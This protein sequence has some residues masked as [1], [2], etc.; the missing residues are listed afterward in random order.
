MSL[1]ISS[2]KRDRQSLRRQNQW[3]K[4]RQRTKKGVARGGNE[5]IALRWRVAGRTADRPRLPAPVTSSSS[6]EVFVVPIESRTRTTVEGTRE[7][8]VHSPGKYLFSCPRDMV[9][10]QRVLKLPFLKFS[11]PSFRIDHVRAATLIRSIDFIARRDAQKSHYSANIIETYLFENSC[12]T[13]K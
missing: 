12:L 6:F 13:W 7:N 4:G 8:V 2:K 9:D 3:K 1:T 10:A 11:G 5:L